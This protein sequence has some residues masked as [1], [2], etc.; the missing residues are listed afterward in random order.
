MKENPGVQA[1]QLV[2]AYTLNKLS[3]CLNKSPNAT[4]TTTMKGT[5][6]FEI[7]LVKGDSIPVLVCGICGEHLHDA[8]AAAAVYNAKV[9]DGEQVQ[10]LYVHKGRIDGHT[11]HDE[12]DAMIEANGG[13]PAWQELR[14]HLMSLVANCGITVEQLLDEERRNPRE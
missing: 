13:I 6:M 12:A 9:R 7:H 14:G 11:C 8:S 4:N 1:V 2:Q 10:P 5:T 3:K